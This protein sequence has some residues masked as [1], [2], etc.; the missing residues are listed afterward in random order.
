MVGNSVRRC[1]ANKLFSQV[2]PADNPL[3]IAYANTMTWLIDRQNGKPAEPG[4]K[5]VPVGVNWAWMTGLNNLMD[6]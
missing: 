4:C 5:L 6:R 3:Q 1:L 2:H